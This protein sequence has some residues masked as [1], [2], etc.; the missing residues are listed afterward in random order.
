MAKVRLQQKY[1]KV[2]MKQI[3]PGVG[4]SR[5]TLIPTPGLHTPAFVR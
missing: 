5:E 4:V 2:Q 1:T 3:G